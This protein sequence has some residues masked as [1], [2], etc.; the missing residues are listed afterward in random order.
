VFLRGLNLAEAA[1]RYKFAWGS[2]VMAQICALSYIWLIP[3]LNSWSLE[4][5]I[6]GYTAVDGDEQPAFKIVTDEESA[7]ARES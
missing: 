5:K 4:A 3:Q 7:A 1:F 6:G 2:T